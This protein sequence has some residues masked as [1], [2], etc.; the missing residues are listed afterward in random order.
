[1]LHIATCP[2]TTISVTIVKLIKNHWSL[3]QFMRSA[4]YKH[5]TSRT[6]VTTAYKNIE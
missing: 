5:G 3:L 2:H 4:I 6:D 1:M